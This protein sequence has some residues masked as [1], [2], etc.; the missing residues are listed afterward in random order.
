[1]I[2]LTIDDVEVK[3]QEG[4]TILEAASHVPGVGRIPTLCHSN[5]PALE[6]LKPA[7]AC[8]VCTVE[9]VDGGKSR[10]GLACVTAAKEGM[11]VYT[12]SDEVK[13]RRVDIVSKLLARCSDVKVIKEL[14]EEVGATAPEGELGHDECILCGMCER[15][16]SDPRGMG[17]EAIK[18][19]KN[20]GLSYYEVDTEKCYGCGDCMIACALGTVKLVDGKAVI[21][22]PKAASKK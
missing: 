1:M 20:N 6:G 11:V 10:F 7:R 9:I 18:A 16:C 19:V 21:P 12:N 15:T 14:A 5:W 2:T 3:A 22:R 17:M 8:R 13:K 4:S